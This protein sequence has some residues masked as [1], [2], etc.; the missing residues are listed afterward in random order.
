M[1]ASTPVVVA[2]KS[3]SRASQTAPTSRAAK[4]RLVTGGVFD[5]QSRPLAGAVVQVAG[6]TVSTSTNRLGRFQLLAQAEGAPVLVITAAGFVSQELELTDDDL[7]PVTAVLDAAPVD[8]GQTT[9]AAS[10]REENVFKVPI[11]LDQITPD[12]LS[13]SGAPDPVFGA[14]ATVKGVDQTASSMLVTNFST[15]GFNS[16]QT[17]R[18]MQLT[19]FADGQSPTLSLNLGSL[20]GAAPLDVA[21][22]ELIHG[23][24]SALYGANA[25]NG[26]LLTTTKDAFQTPGLTVQLRGGSQNLRDVQA[27]YAVRLGTRWAAKLNVGYLTATDWIADNQT[28]QTARYD[29]LNHS[30]DDAR[31][32][33]AVNRYGDV[34]LTYSASGGALAGQ[35]V[36][37][38]GWTERELLGSDAQARSLRLNPSVSYQINPNLRATYE[39]RFTQATGTFQSLDRYRLDNVSNLLHRVELKAP[40]WALRAFRAQEGG[41]GAFGLTQLGGRMQTQLSPATG[42]QL[43]YAQHYFGTYAQAYNAW[44]A[45]NPTDQAGALQAARA[46]AAPTQPVA[47]T[48]AFDQLIDR[49]K[50]TNSTN[51]GARLPAQS[52][53]SDV[54]GQ[55]DLT[56]AGVNVLVGG[57]YRH[58][59]LASQGT[60][61]EEE[62]GKGPTN[63]Q[64]GGYVEAARALFDRRLRL[65]ATARLDAFQ[66]FDAAFSPRLGATVLLGAARNHA[67]RA[68][69]GQA[70]TAPTQTQQ[71][72]RLDAGSA[73]VLG[74]AANGFS[75]YGTSVLQGANP[76]A[77]RISLDPL[78]LEHAT[79]YEA[80]YRTLLGPR[81]LIDLSYFDTRYDDF[82][83]TRTLIGKT[84]G[85][86][87][88]LT[89]VATF[90]QPGS[91][92]RAI[93]TWY[94][95]PATLHL[96]GL[97][98]EARWFASADVAVWANY[99]LSNLKPTT[100]TPAVDTRPLTAEELFSAPLHKL[101]V[102]LTGSAGALRY[103]VAVRWTAAYAFVSPFA[104][105]HLPE[106]TLLDASLGYAIKQTGLMCFIGGTNLTNTPNFSVFGGPSLGRQITA[107][108]RFDLNQ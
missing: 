97:T 106:R 84:D 17:A 79:T 9:F 85:S 68:S 40:H 90:G 108:L 60:L 62:N 74:N 37:L 77:V 15:R 80:G 34:G 100:S 22:V 59:A 98:A 91:L 44:L 20:F 96:N 107:G 47:G 21:R 19:D 45:A 2:Q 67:F 46:A 7:T 18:V 8:L 73:I 23:P 78:R 31:G 11:T 42:E 69:Y 5:S 6:S 72:L 63:Y 88:T 95:D 93:Q 70:Y 52:T 102:G 64:A 87:P 56:V 26:V 48:A 76:A 30:A 66:N 50:N 4:Y 101:N 71:Y 53:L 92:V 36:Y 14:L 28:A 57:N 35:R 83:G 16:T 55:Y 49:V 105:G 65:T 3:A 24:A 41:N 12:Q 1:V 61:F 10:R 94:N 38:P 86:L 25:F 32:Y 33:N 89:E 43:T 13:R 103:D 82:V 58:V 104:E 27:R 54:S 81:L 39:L 99:S 75:G 51:G 29:A